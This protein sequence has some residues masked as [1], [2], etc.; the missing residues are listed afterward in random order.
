MRRENMNNL[1][2]LREARGLTQQKLAEQFRLSQ[3]TIHKYEN[4][5][6]EP[7]IETMKL[8]AGFFHTTIDYLVDFASE[9]EPGSVT[10]VIEKHF[11]TPSDY[12]HLYLYRK[13]S[14]EIKRNFDAILE[15]LLQ[16]RDDK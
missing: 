10:G 16:K 4:G 12:H 8:M 6:A 13:L 7:D 14:N 11:I 9:S 5:L 2:K 15:E 1:K 3:Q